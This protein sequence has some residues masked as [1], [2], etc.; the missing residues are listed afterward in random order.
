MRPRDIRLK[1]P[2]TRALVPW[3]FFSFA[4][5]LLI[6][7]YFHFSW[8]LALFI[9][10]NIGAFLLYG[11]DKMIAGTGSQRIPERILW[12]SAFLG[13]SIGAVTGMYLFRHKTKKTS[14]QLVLAILV[15]VQIALVVL[16]LKYH[17]SILTQ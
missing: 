6:G 1:S 10:L 4:S 12:L 2:H 7:N 16:Y 5:A 11:L 14:F 8:L 15:L 9:G 3:L 17:T 13:G